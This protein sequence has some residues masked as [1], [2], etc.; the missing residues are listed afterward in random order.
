MIKCLKD[1]TSTGLLSCLRIFLF[2]HHQNLDAVLHVISQPISK[3]KQLDCLCDLNVF[4]FSCMIVSLSV[5]SMSLISFLFRRWYWAILYCFVQRCSFCVKFFLLEKGGRK[6]SGFL[7]EA[8]LFL[9]SG[10]RC[11]CDLSINC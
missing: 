7:C 8:K 11:Y 6:R 1:L 10:K 5:K 2:S 9:C 3:K 4:S